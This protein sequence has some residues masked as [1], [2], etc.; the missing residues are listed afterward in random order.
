MGG[1]FE[2]NWQQNIICRRSGNSDLQRATPVKLLFIRSRYWLTF[3]CMEDAAYFISPTHRTFLTSLSKCL[4]PAT[5]KLD[6]ILDLWN[7]TLYQKYTQIIDFP[8]IGKTCIHDLYIVFVLLFID[9]GRP[10][11]YLIWYW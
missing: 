1:G 4:C 2:Y 11:Y 10:K 5:D 9:N 3:T 6:H 8:C 7:K